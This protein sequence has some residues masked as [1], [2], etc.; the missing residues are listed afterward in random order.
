MPILVF[1]CI[2]DTFLFSTIGKSSQQFP[3]EGRSILSINQLF[4]EVKIPI[5]R[6]AQDKP[7]NF[8]AHHCPQTHTHI[9]HTYNRK[10]YA[11][12]SQ[13]IIEYTIIA[14]SQNNPLN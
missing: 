9:D 13:L 11:R 2:I 5:Y 8:I 1:I 7:L 10:H 3:V 6:C 14:V 12:E 4:N